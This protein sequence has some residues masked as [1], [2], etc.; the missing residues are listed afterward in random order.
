MPLESRQ[1]DEDRFHR[2]KYTQI[3]YRYHLPFSA[4]TAHQQNPALT[5]SRYRPWSFVWQLVW[6]VQEFFARRFRWMR[7][8]IAIYLAHR[9]FCCCPSR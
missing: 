4:S 9:L 2:K 6:Q 8:D 1:L 3:A 5:S 7:L